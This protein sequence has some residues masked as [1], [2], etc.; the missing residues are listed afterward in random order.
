MQQDDLTA[1]FKSAYTD[2]SAPKICAA[3]GRINLI[4]EH[5]DYCGVPVLPMAI[6]RAVTVAFA[7]HSDGEVRVANVDDQFDSVSFAVADIG[8]RAEGNHWSDY[9]KAA[10]KGLN[11]FFEM[12]SGPGIDLL[13]SSTL[14]AAA[15]LSSSSA[16]VVATSLAYLSVIEKELDKD[17]TRTELAE[18]LAKAERYVGTQAGGMDQSIILLGETAHATKIDFFPLRVEH[19]PIPDDLAIVA[20]H[21]MVNAEKSGDAQGG[22]NEGPVTCKIVTRLIEK[23]LQY[24]YGEDIEIGHL[25]DLWLGPLCMTHEEVASLMED[26]LKQERMTLQEVAGVLEIP[27]EELLES[28]PGN[29]L[30]PPQGFAIQAKARHERTEFRRVE[31]A[32]D[33]LLAEDGETLGQLMVESHRS[34]AEDFEISTPELDELV[35]VALGGGAMGARLTGAGFGGCTVNLVPREKVDAFTQ[36]VAKAYYEKRGVSVPLDEVI[37]PLNAAARADYL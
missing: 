14:P 34:C 3:P 17:L 30:Q 11:T 29:A 24:E 32:R 12:E 36:H 10:I 27:E 23:H 33:A 8:S 19:V 22:Y 18:C 37:L 16:L 21:S 35:E 20:C 5:T 26:A 9:C 28:L 25:G 1:R 6:D 15:G 2:A 13:V 4:G 7:P 31:L